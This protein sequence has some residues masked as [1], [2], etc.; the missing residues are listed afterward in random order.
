M[1]TTNYADESYAAGVSRLQ[2]GQR[3]YA[4]VIK[5]LQDALS[6]IQAAIE[7]RFNAALIKDNKPEVAAA[8]K[9][10]RE[11]INQYV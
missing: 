8:L 4:R 9:E 6:L 7:T 3:E 5:R 11:E 10:L 2:D 1:T